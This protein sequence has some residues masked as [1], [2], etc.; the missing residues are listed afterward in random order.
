MGH[1]L[2][3][4]LKLIPGYSPLSPGSCRVSA[5]VENGTTSEL[6]IPAR[7]IVCQLGLA[8]RIPKLIYPSD[9]YDNDHD[10]EEMDDTD[11]GLTYKQFEQ[12]KSVS[13]Q[14]KTE[15]ELESEDHSTKE[16]IE[17]LGPDM[18]EDIKT[19][20][21][22]SEDA[23]SNS[24]NSKEEVMDHG[25]DRID[26]SGLEN[27]PEQLQ[28][29]AT[30][31]LKRNAKVFSKTDMDMGRT[32]LVKHH[33][34]LTDPVPFKEAYRRIPLQMYDEVKAHI[35][36][37]LDLG[38]IRPSNSPWASAIVLVRKK[39]GRLRFCID[40]RRLNN[41]TIKDAYSLPKIESIL[42]SLIGA[43]IF[44]TLD[45]K[46][47]YWQVEMAEEFK[48]YTVFTCGPLGFY[49][50]DTMS[51]GATNA[52]ATFQRLMHDCL[53]DVNMNWCIVYLDDI[54]IFSDTKEKHLKR[55]EAA[56]QKLAAAGLKLKPSKCFFFK[57][58]IEY[59]GHVVS[60]K[61]IATN[62]K[63]AEAVTKW[64]TPKTIYDVRSLLGF[65]EYYR[66]FI[67][68]FSK[69]PKPIREVITGLENQSKRT[70]KKTFIE[71]TE[72]ADS[73]FEHLKKLC[74][75]TPILAYPDYQ[76]PFVLHTDSSSEGLGAVLYQRQEDKLRVIAYASRP[77]SK[78]ESHYPAH[79]LEFLALKW[80]V[81]EKFH[82][83][84]YDSKS[85]KVYTD[86]NPLTYVLTSAKL[87]ACGQRWVAK[88]AIYNFTIKYKCGLSN[89]EADA[90]SR[91][92]WPEVLADSEDLD[93]NLECMDTHIVNAVLTGSKSKSS[94]IESVSCSP[95]IIPTEL[96][97]DS[98]SSSAIDW[99][100]EQRADP[101]LSVIIKLIESGQLQKRKLHGK[102]SPE[103][104]ILLR[105]R[106]SLKL[107][108]DIL[109][110]KGYSDNSSSK[111]VL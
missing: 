59:L 6:T 50:C 104:K 89:V 47:G 11:E 39:D 58:E 7:T 15:S 103:V 72:A 19:Q 18:E 8:N 29:E 78:S 49:E 55:L 109:Y 91:I 28:I 20:N 1:N 17:D 98:G 43:Q 32:N 99:I 48:A 110:R 21:Q 60:G 61:G 77:V 94:L 12:Y 63:K 40:L 27:W 88:L 70:A 13:E 67:K 95:K 68:D 16:E 101:N 86:N 82:E 56:F 83:Y 71:W 106:K 30:E 73:A 53:G 54:I 35:Q 4:G 2:P 111:K 90:L 105:I 41:R 87:D 31:M 9:D 100:K 22:G 26:L 65:V 75:S 25:L 96:N 23:N 84:R 10:P 34:K 79:K 66:R 51:F 46:A 57:E 80:A 76:L 38:D 3:K 97:L 81:C 62:P 107:V 45:L 52:P 36:E 108:K 42:D 5:V 74:T 69:I 64:P 44:S 33:I 24:N 102:D 93:I 14:L 92:S 85:F 37:M